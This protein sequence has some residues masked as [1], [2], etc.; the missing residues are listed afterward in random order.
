M[1]TCLKNKTEVASIIYDIEDFFP[2]TLR[3]R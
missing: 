1:E 2:Y 3:N